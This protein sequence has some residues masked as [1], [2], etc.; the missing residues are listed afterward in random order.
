[1]IFRKYLSKDQKQLQLF[2]NIIIFGFLLFLII[3]ETRS[4]Y[5]VN[6]IPVLLLAS[7]LGIIALNN[8]IKKVDINV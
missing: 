3:W 8:K 2:L 7:Y 6:I 5:I 1:M 4:R